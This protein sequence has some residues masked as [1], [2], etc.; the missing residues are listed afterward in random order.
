MAAYDQIKKVKLKDPITLGDSA[1][2]LYPVTGINAIMA[3]TSGD[4]ATIYITGSGSGTQIQPQYLSIINSS[5]YVGDQYLQFIDPVDGKII[6]NYLKFIV[7]AA[8]PTETPKIS[9]DYLPSYVDDVRDVP[10]INAPDYADSSAYQLMIQVGSV[11]GVPTYTFY[12]WSGSQWVIG[13]GQP[14]TIYI[15]ANDAGIGDGSIYRCKTGSTTQAI[16]ISENPYAIDTTV[17]NGV[18]LVNNNTT[19]SAQAALATN[20][21]PGTVIINTASP[22]ATNNVSLSVSNGT[23]SVAAAVASPQQ[24]GIVFAVGTL[25][26]YETRRSAHGDSYLVPTAKW[27]LDMIDSGLAGI[28]YATTTTPG[29][30]Q[31]DPNGHITVN[32]SGVIAVPNAGI[33]TA[34]V[35]QIVDNIDTTATGN[36]GKAVTQAGIVSYVTSAVNDRQKTLT[37]GSGIGITNSNVISAK[38]GGEMLKFDSN[39][40]IVGTPATSTTLGGVVVTNDSSFIENG[41]ASLDGKPIAVNPQA[42]SNYVDGAF[43]DRTV[44]SYADMLVSSN[45]NKLGTVSAVMAYVDISIADIEPMHEGDAIDIVSGTINVLYDSNTLNLNTANKLT[46]KSATADMPGIVKPG[47][48]LA[49]SAGG[50]MYA[51]K[52]TAAAEFAVAGNSGKF[53]TV[54]AI[55][56]YVEGA[57]QNLEPMHEGTAIDL[58]GGTI[59]VLY[60][61][62]TLDI[63]SGNKLTVQKVTAATEF[64]VASNSSKFATVA[65]ISDYVDNSIADLTPV[66][67]G[68]AIDVV[69]GTTV[70]VNLLYDTSV[71]SVTDNKVTVRPAT[72]NSLGIVR[73]PTSSGLVLTDGV[74]TLDYARIGQLGGVKTATANTGISVS[75]GGQIQVEISQPLYFNGNAIAV[76]SATTDSGGIVKILDAG[77]DIGIDSKGG[78]VPVASA[79]KEY[80]ASM[81]AGGTVTVTENTGIIVTSSSTGSSTQYTV[82]ARILTP[83]ISSGSA[84]T[85]QT[86]SASIDGSLGDNTL[87]AVYVRGATIRTD[88]TNVTEQAS[89]VPTE[90]AVRDAIN[91]IPYITYEEMS[92]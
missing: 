80:V 18:G 49:V 87:G 11:G 45:S 14:S 27:T 34:G 73:V 60:D 58:D 35:V 12:Q 30:V 22:T 46:V 89:T 4:N 47:D 1:A 29:I 71:M 38:I 83:I 6:D 91:A 76:S 40:A 86:A 42:V 8:S 33:T 51:P 32:T 55:S 77:T 41:S 21:T 19:I 15:A 17:T 9:Q 84:I 56:N 74:V 44:S 31:I 10:V 5:G 65:A 82:G 88:F 54:A 68:T 20:S 52:I 90:R 66:S 50:A 57:I 39:G 81:I 72:N 78:A 85:V 61:S 79:V 37:A 67:G 48:G 53:A 70:S 16:K 36:A 64:D 75:A 25:A 2:I 7:P 92:N 24:A 62:S 69:S 23:V 13:G 63:A 43:T 59:N 28:S 3:G 26:D